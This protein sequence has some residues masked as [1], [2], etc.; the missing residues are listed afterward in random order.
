MHY[1][2][3][4]ALAGRG[5]VPRDQLQVTLQ[6]WSLS[7]AGQRIHGTTRSRPLDRFAHEQ[8]TLL[9]LPP[10]AYDLAVWSQ[11]KVGRDCYVSVDQAWYSAPHR[12]VGQSIWV[13][14][15]IRTVTLYGDDHVAIYTHDRAEPGERRT[16]L[17]HLPP[18]KVPGLTLTRESAVEQARGIG[19]A[20]LAVVEQLLAERPV[21]KL[22][23]AGR[24]LRLAG[25]Y[26]GPRLE[27][28]CQDALGYGEAEYGLIKTILRGKPAACA[29]TD[30]SPTPRG[31]AFARDA[32][33]YLVGR[34]TAIAGG[35]A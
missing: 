3:R 1:V 19:P 15:G 28:A 4:S 9:P 5:L 25:Q 27:R 31:F 21:D 11:P 30:P 8:G 14:R 13:R 29:G 17:D 22:R 10:T 26:D 24:L 12:L 33:E 20:T 23:V 34:L 32:K 18:G 2:K 7:E 6:A 35:G 16:C